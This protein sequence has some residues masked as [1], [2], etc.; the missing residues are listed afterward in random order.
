VSASEDLPGVFL[1][2]LQRERDAL[3]VHI[4]LEDL[5]GDFLSNFHN[6]TGVLDVLPA[7]LGDVNETVHSTEVDECSEVH[8]RRH[9]TLADLTLGQVLEERGAVLA[10]ARLEKSAA[11]EDNVVPVL[12]EL[13]DFGFHFL[14]QV[15]RQIAHSAK[16][17]Q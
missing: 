12:V 16:L 11:G 2:R 1:S 14:T 6:F 8:D 3:A 15:G 4:D 10:L 7:E 5:D 13:E 17:N 9:N